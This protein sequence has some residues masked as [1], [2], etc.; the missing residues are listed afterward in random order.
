MSEYN[1]IL[2]RHYLLLKNNGL[3]IKNTF[4]DI[5]SENNINKLRKCKS[6][7]DLILLDDKNINFNHIENIKNNNVIKKNKE[8]KNKNDNNIDDILMELNI[9]NKKKK[10]KTLTDE[11][12]INDIM[13]DVDV[14]II[15]KGVYDQ[16]NEHIENFRKRNK[17][18]LL[19]MYND[20]DRKLNVNILCVNKY[21]KTATAI[22]LSTIR[23]KIYLYLINNLEKLKKEKILKIYIEE[24]LILR[25]REYEEN[26]TRTF[27]SHIVYN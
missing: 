5:Y 7:N 12:L 24:T 16:I 13:I 15:K 4:I 6:L 19:K 21:I 20:N 25:F 23:N 9:K 22:Y 2:D 11:E 18:I 14:F 1:T 10:R 27:E 26:I 17:N 3:H 8:K